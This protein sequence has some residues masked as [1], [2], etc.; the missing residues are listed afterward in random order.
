MKI[1]LIFIGD[2]VIGTVFTPVI[3]SLQLQLKATFHFEVNEIR[4]NV[5]PIQIFR[6]LRVFQAR[7]LLS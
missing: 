7:E 3:C 5:F 4:I 6:S 1:S 2:R